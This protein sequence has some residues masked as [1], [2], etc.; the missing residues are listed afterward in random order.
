MTTTEALRWAAELYETEARNA[1]RAMAAVANA[2]AIEAKR[3]AGRRDL[4][5]RQAELDADL[6]AMPDVQLVG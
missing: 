5:S 1:E 4:A 6:A 2:R 3:A